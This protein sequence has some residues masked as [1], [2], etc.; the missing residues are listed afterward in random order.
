MRGHSAAK[1]EDARPL[2]ATDQTDCEQPKRQRCDTAADHSRQHGAAI[3]LMTMEA[4]E[5]WSQKS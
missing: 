4:M 5:A 3:K 2:L 1:G